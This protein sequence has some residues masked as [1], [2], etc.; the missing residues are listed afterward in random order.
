MP[1]WHRP[2]LLSVTESRC[3][4]AEWRLP[5]YLEEARGSRCKARGRGVR[6]C[7]NSLGLMILI[8]PSSW[9]SPF[10]WN[11]WRRALRWRDDAQ[12]LP[13]T[14]PKAKSHAVLPRQMQR[15]ALAY[16]LVENGPSTILDRV[17][18]TVL[19][20]L[21]RSAFRAVLCSRGGTVSAPAPSWQFAGSW[22]HVCAFLQLSI[23]SGRHLSSELPSCRHVQGWCASRVGSQ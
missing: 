5:A 14:N 3:P 1:F 22:P 2:H 13:A 10:L 8:I 15:T 21:R 18:N 23:V 16:R 12:R 19:W 4:L 17:Y 20:R 6:E 11:F 7:H 9:S